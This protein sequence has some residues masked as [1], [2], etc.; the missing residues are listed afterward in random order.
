MIRH[1]R[2]YDESMYATDRFEFTFGVL[3]ESLHVSYSREL[4]TLSLVSA[5]AF[6]LDALGSSPRRR[7]ATSA[8]FAA[9]QI[10]FLLSDRSAYNNHYYLAALLASIYFA[11]DVDT[12]LVGRADE[13]MYLRLLQ[14]QVGIVYAFATYAKVSSLNWLQ[15]YPAQIWF[16]RAFER[17][18]RDVYGPLATPRKDLP[19]IL[20]Y[21][22]SYGGIT[23][24]LFLAVVFLKISLSR[25]RTYGLMEMFAFWTCVAFHVTNALIFDIGVFPYLMLATLALYFDRFDL[26]GS[27]PS[28]RANRKPRRARKELNTPPRCILCLRLIL[29][30]CYA[31]AQLVVPLRYLRHADISRHVDWT[32]QDEMFSWRMMLTSKECDGYFQVQ[33][34]DKGVRRIVRTL[35]D[36]EDFHIDFLSWWRMMSDAEN[37]RQ[38][39]VRLRREEEKARGGRVEIHADVRCSLNGSEKQPYVDSGVDFSRVQHAYQHV[40][41]Q[42]KFVS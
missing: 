21:A 28:L 16:S 39:A 19:R 38:M 8:A 14:W 40:A 41:G 42:T 32:S 18:V 25:R 4:L 34:V 5:A 22:F 1:L 13:Y 26:F 27:T 35:R 10:L 30:V 11:T 24:D 33:R 6:A 3:P 37:I 7:C 23:I 36:P 17:A 12:C 2:A 15:G 31:T 9:T 20:A 29:V